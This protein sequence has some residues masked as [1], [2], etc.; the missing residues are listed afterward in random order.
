MTSAVV[1]HSTKGR[2]EEKKK[3]KAQGG[4]GKKRESPTLRD[5]EYLILLD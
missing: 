4:G 5:Y 1:K 3:K 2:K